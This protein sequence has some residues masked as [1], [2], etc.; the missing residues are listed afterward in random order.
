MITLILVRHGDAEPQVD[1]KDDKDRRLVK[2]GVKQMR[3]VSNF[4]EELGFNVDRIISSPYLRAYQSA[5]VIL[6]ELYDNDSEKKVET[7]DDL[8]PDKEPSLFLEKLKDFA[9]NSTILVV[10]HEPYL[11]NFVKAISGGNVEIKK[12]G[13]VIVDYDLKEGR[14]VL[15]TLLSQK[16]LKLI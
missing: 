10:G 5:E 2:K 13:V 9:D 11:S 12:G 15:K 6:E 1:G 14:G 8:T 16:V 4:L 7:L 3:R